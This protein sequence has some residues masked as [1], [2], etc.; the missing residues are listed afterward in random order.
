LRE[1]APRSGSSSSSSARTRSRPCARRADQAALE[2][3]AEASRRPCPLR[4]R[5]RSRRDDLGAHVPA[6]MLF[7]ASRGGI[8]HSSAEFTEP[9][10]ASSAP[11]AREALARARLV[12][13]RAASD[14]RPLPISSPAHDVTGAPALAASLE[15]SAPRPRSAFSRG[16]KE[17]E[18]QG[19]DIIHLEIGEPDFTTPAH[20]CEAAAEALRRARPTTARRREF[21]SFARRRPT[22]SRTSRDRGSPESV[23]VGTGAKPFLFFHD[24]AGTNP[25]TRSSTPIRVSDLRVGDPVGPGRRRAAASRRGRDF[26]FD[27]ADLAARLSPRT[28]LVILN[29]PQNPTGGV[30]GP[31]ETAEAAGSLLESRTRGSSRTRSTRRCCTRAS[32]RASPR[33]R[34]CSSG[35]VLPRRPLEDVRDDRLALRLRERCPIRSSTRS[36][37]SSSTRRLRAA[38]RAARR[39]DGADGPQDEPRAMIEEFRRRRDLVVAGL[40]DLPGVTCRTRAAPSTRSERRRRADPAD[41]LAARL[42]DEAGSRSSP[43]PRSARLAVRTSASLT[44]T[45]RRTSPAPS[46]GCAIFPD[47]SGELASP[48]AHRPPRRRPTAR[49]GRGGRT[50][51][52]SGAPRSA[53]TR[54]ARLPSYGFGAHHGSGSG[55]VLPTMP[56]GRQWRTLKP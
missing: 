48:V 42:L 30:V 10:T 51:S 40:N 36:F 25:A 37:A 56:T 20:V 53:R 27:L 14:G 11:R 46:T 3:A 4:Q 43:A 8:S 5:R 16:R 12:A 32:S 13:R 38:F 15:R 35:T 21:R 29:S 39:G 9:A 50:R 28:K 34:A 7:R 41:E 47:L 23:L 55:R 22:T 17:L 31:E 18:R 45:R 44:P 1:I 33:T 54:L 6:G 19:R 52:R 49:G 2:R 26:V 24:L